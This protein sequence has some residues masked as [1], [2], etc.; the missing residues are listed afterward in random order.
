M[1]E[2]QIS[3]R[4]ENVSGS[5]RGRNKVSTKANVNI[6]LSLGQLF[7]DPIYF[8]AEPQYQTQAYF[9]T[10]IQLRNAFQEE[11]KYSAILAVRAMF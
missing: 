3:N 2:L 8:E 1:C 9:K 7:R 6:K 4:V 5:S 10:N 11:G